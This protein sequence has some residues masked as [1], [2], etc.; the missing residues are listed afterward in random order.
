[1]PHTQVLLSVFNGEA[2]LDDLLTSLASQTAS[3]ISV[4]ARDDG[5]TDNSRP[6]AASYD[7]VELVSGANLGPTKSFF[8]LLE[9][10]DPSASYF[11]FCD[12][13]DVWMPDKVAAAV[14]RLGQVDPERPAL[15]FAGYTVTDSRLRP[16]RDRPPLR[17]PPSFANALIENV[18]TGATSV[19]NA[20]ARDLIVAPRPSELPAIPF[21]HDSWVYQVISAFGEVLYDP[22]PR[23]FYRQ[24][25]SQVVGQRRGW[26]L[27]KARMTRY[28]NFSLAPWLQ[29]A[30]ALHRVHG[31][32]VPPRNRSIL[33]EFLNAG[34]NLATRFRYLFNGDV[35]RQSP[36]E[37]AVFRAMR[38]LERPS[39]D[40][41]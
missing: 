16:I 25:G 3:N 2:F 31:P 17:R 9:L 27:W 30:V 13:D 5:S 36:L 4:L 10:S 23:M 38:S 28:S 41:D 32:S 11:A 7:G 8:K 40:V 24:H 1:M 21:L 39:R 29:Q 19:I 22:K 37:T 6:L 34:R 33:E 15:Y 26:D 20:A 14:T 18:A 12:Q 35:Y